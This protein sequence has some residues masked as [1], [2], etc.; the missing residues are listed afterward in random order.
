MKQ[1]LFLKSPPL[2]VLLCL[3]LFPSSAA[4]CEKFLVS[5]IGLFSAGNS[6]KMKGERQ[7]NKVPQEKRKKE[8]DTYLLDVG[9]EEWRHFLME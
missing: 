1:P 9:G 4:A 6:L 5:F 7:R 2:S 3:Q 8:E